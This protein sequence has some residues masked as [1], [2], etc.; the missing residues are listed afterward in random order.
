MKIINTV[1]KNL[2]EFLNALYTRQTTNVLW[3][4]AGMALNKS[5]VIGYHCVAFTKK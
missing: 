5:N 2:C 1:V 4:A 3:A